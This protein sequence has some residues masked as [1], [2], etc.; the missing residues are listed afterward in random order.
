MK[1]MV[2]GAP[3]QVRPLQPTLVKPFHRPG[4]VYEEKVDGWRMVAYKDA[5]KVSLVSRRGVDLTERFPRVA[6]AIASLPS[7]ALVLDGEVAVFDERL[8]SRFDL[9]SEP[10]PDVVVT[11]PVYVAFDVLYAGQQDY[12]AQ[13]L[14]ARREALEGLV[15]GTG[16][17]FAVRRLDNDGHKAWEEVQRRGLE[18]FVG[19]DPASTYLRGGPTRLWLKSKVRQEG[20]F[21]VGGVVETAEGWSLLLGSP[22]RGQLTYRGAVH[23]GLGRELA[24]ALTANGLARSTSPFSEPVPLK[25]VKWLD[26][27]L[28]AQVSYAD[29]MQGGK[30]RAGVFRGFV[31]S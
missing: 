21:V 10:D 1:V 31:G 11:P 24:E 23:F 6:K 26:P 13:P 16:G 7:E 8:V 9:L 19:K 27:K 25:G 14:T 15:D 28:M 17:V 12:R 20:E 5:S 30:L 2:R 4:W 3:F 22:E 29:I 18:G